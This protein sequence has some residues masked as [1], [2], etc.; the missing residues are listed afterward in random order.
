MA[1]DQLKDRILGWCSQA[2][3]IAVVQDR[4]E[5]GA[6]VALLL[7]LQRPEGVRLG[8]LK[9][10][11]DDRV[12][13]L[14][15]VRFP[16]G[17]IK[18]GDG[19][20][21]AAPASLGEAVERIIEARMGSLSGSTRQ[22]SDGQEVTLT[23]VIYAD[24]LTKHAFLTAIQ[25]LARVRRVLDRM[26]AGDLA[27]VNP[28]FPGGAASSEGD[29]TDQG[30]GSETPIP[31][32]ATAAAASAGAATAAAGAAGAGPSGGEAT[33]PAD[34]GSKQ[35]G[36]RASP[37]SPAVKEPESAAPGSAEQAST[38]GD[39]SGGGA[40]KDAPAPAA[41]Q[42]TAPQPAVPAPTPVPTAGQP[43]GWGNRPTGAPAQQGPGQQAAAQQGPGRP[44][45]EQVAPDQ[46]APVVQ[47]APQPQ[48]APASTPAWTPSHRVPPAGMDAWAQPD[49]TQRAI[50][51][52]DGGV[53]L[54]VTETAGA[55]AHILCSNGWTGWVDF[56]ILVPASR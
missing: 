25:E 24:G 36:V 47:P 3:E 28:V 20:G 55:W 54:Q 7:R 19:G 45:A 26:H 41:P 32:A 27:E 39:G 11:G 18:L 52:I 6:E 30:R 48:P 44:G 5:G 50:A 1:Q 4:E 2:S 29:T 31:A 37:S 40:S 35:A 16:S 34:G 21:A 43:A 22:T 51:R 56:R 8:V 42:P 17:S 9:P 14:H 33:G 46:P 10:T 23:S 12:S 13:V 15:T 38:G 49:P 53:P